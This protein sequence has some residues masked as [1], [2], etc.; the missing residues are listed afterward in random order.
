MNNSRVGET[1]VNKHGSKMEIVKYD[2]ANDVW[3]K[4]IESDYI[5]KT[6]Y[7]NFKRG[8][9]K[10]PYDKTV[11][12]V[13][14]LGVGKYKAHVNLKQTKQ[15]KAWKSMMTRCYY[16]EHLERFPTYYGCSVVEDWHNYQNFGDWYDKNYYEIDGE[17]MQ[18]DKD[19]LIKGN[20]TYSPE[21]CIFV[22]QSIN[23]V[24]RKGG[25]KSGNKMGT[26]LQLAEKY[27]DKIPT[28][29]YEIMINYQV[30]D[31]DY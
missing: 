30:K 7:G 25:N 24:F 11:Y 23:L 31:D 14:F 4:F 10:S 17:I 15:Y 8:D 22:P 3:V 28:K 6:I 9:I 5:M 29:L 13:G 18:L 19:I 21:A 1:N 27:K 12:G 2:K 16:K 26:M 20:R